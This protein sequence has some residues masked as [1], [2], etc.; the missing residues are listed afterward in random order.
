MWCP[1]ECNPTHH[2]PLQQV[3]LL[4]SQPCSIAPRIG[5]PSSRNRRS[6]PDP[7]HC[8]SKHTG[9]YQSFA[10]A[11]RDGIGQAVRRPCERTWWLRTRCNLPD[12]SV[13]GS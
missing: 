12:G 10:I 3:R 1:N 6:Q 8:R 4:Q 7:K 9:V 5:L 13:Y 11:N 2:P